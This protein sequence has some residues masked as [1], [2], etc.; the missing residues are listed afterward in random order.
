MPFGV[1]FVPIEA[2]IML[3]TF[4]QLSQLAQIAVILL[5]YATL[6]LIALQL[7]PDEQTLGAGIKTVYL[8]VAL[9]W[10][11]MVGIY[12]AGIIGLIVAITARTDFYLWM[13]VIGLVA[14]GFFLGGTVSSV[15]AQIVNWGGIALA[16]PRTLSSLQVIA[17]GIIVLVLSIWN[18][19]KRL[20]GGVFLLWALFTF[21]TTNS[22]EL[23]L[24]P[25]NAIGSSNSDAIRLTF[26][27]L[28]G[29]TLLAAAAIVA[30][31]RPEIPPTPQPPQ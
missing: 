21:W 28:F 2:Q 27:G 3:D 20:L 26:Y 17:A 4:K 13:R 12:L 23:V 15:A 6:V 1:P 19:D 18:I 22:A 29:L 9:I 16:E 30:V 10:V 24:H 11:G 5:V 7:G 31:L 25:A 14:L 8:H